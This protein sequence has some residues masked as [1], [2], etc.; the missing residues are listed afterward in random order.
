M[1]A[2]Y[3]VVRA[4]LKHG[5]ASLLHNG[6]GFCSGFDS[7]AKPGG[8]PLTN[9]LYEL[10]NTVAGQPDGKPLTFGDLWDAPLYPDEPQI[11]NQYHCV[12][13]RE[14]TINFEVMTTNLTL[15][16]PSRIPFDTKRFYFQREEW[17]KLFPA[18]VVD[19]MV[20]HRYAEA[21]PA[22]TPYGQSLV[23]LPEMRDLPVIVAIRM[24]LSFPV[25]LSAVPLYA[26]DY[27]LKKNQGV[28]ESESIGAEKIWFSDGGISSNFPIHLFDSPLPRWP[29]FGI[30]LKA[31]HP[32][33]DTEAEYVWLPRKNIQGLQESWNRFEDNGLFGFLAAIFNVMQNWRD[34]LQMLIPGYRD[35]VVHVSH[36]D[37][38]GGLNLKMDPDVIK[39]MSE[40]GKRAGQELRT[41]FN[42]ENHVW[43]RY[44]SSMCCLETTLERFANSYCHPL[45]QDQTIWPVVQGQGIPPSYPWKGSQSSWA[46]KGTA[47][48]VNLVNM[49]GH[50]GD[51]FCD[52]APRSRPELR[53]GPKV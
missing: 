34:N 2:A 8:P 35:R 9:W 3:L 52:G 46:A 30:N 10:L 48:L 16:C 51:C 18:Q 17:S 19:W 14:R 23:P 26:V 13:F 50:T 41:K 28:S 43:V 32:D 7:T 4:V 6:F 36:T 37:R 15:G 38:E 22:H 1:L 20:K 53:I 39:V 45:A 27:S 24:S 44:R 31:P 33:H 25:L 29:T 5:N 47:D 11:P 21:H 12:E 49:W 40:R 42:W